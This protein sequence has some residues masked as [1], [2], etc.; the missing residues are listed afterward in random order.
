MFEVLIGSRAVRRVSG[1]RSLVVAAVHGIVIVAATR[2]SR[3][4]TPPPP[5]PKVDTTVFVLDRAPAPVVAVSSADP[6]GATATPMDLPPV[7]LTTPTGIPPV[8]LGPPSLP[9]RP[10][11]RNPS[12]PAPVAGPAH[13]EG[14]AWL[15][16]EVDQ[17]AVPIRQPSPRYPPI[18]REAGIEGRVELEFVIDTSGRVEEA[19]LRVVSH[20]A[21]GFDA[22]AIEVISRSLFAPARVKGQVVRQRA[23]QAIAFRI[24][25]PG[26]PELRE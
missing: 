12:P 15:E 19:S 13:R 17:P 20:S 11:D 3:A 2:A 22:A 7:P 25:T 10:W 16:A 6:G 4:P 1:G 18:L 21:D 9:A 5:P 24:R 23:R 14:G 8:L 26:A